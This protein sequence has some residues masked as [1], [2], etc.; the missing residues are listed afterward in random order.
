MSARITEAQA[1]A[2]G[3]EV[4]TKVRT[5]RRVAKGGTYHTKCKT[6]GEEFNTI[7]AEDRHLHDT[8]HARYEI[9]LGYAT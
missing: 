1:R 9:V 6:C 2:M 5:T 8:H 4:P 7:A 3:L